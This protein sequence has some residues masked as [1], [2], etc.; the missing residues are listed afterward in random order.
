MFLVCV[1]I[2]MWAWIH[3]G[4][5]CCPWALGVWRP[6]CPHTGTSLDNSW[7]SWSHLDPARR[8]PRRPRLGARAADC[9]YQLWA[10]LGVPC[11]PFTEGRQPLTCSLS[12]VQCSWLRSMLGEEVWLSENSREVCDPSVSTTSGLFWRDCCVLSTQLRKSGCFPV[13]MFKGQILGFLLKLLFVQFLFV[14]KA[15]IPSFCTTFKIWM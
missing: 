8:G 3:Y 10:A 12:F 15:K 5:P 2:K 7:H 13:D 9:G 4:K 14:D 11:T 1:S 6:C